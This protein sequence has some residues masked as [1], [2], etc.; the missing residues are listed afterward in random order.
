MRNHELHAHAKQVQRSA[1][2]SSV[3]AA[4]YRAAERL[5]DER[6]GEIHDYTAKQGVEHTRI[7]TPDNAPA[8]A[9]DRSRLWNAAEVKENRDNSTTA[10]ELEVG[11]PSEFNAMQR[12]EAGDRIAQELVRRYGCAVDIAYHQPSRSGDQRNHHAHV[13]FT[14][15]A[16]DATRPD[17]WART[18]YRDLAHDLKDK[19]TGEKYRDQ[20]G[21]PTTRGKLE[22]ADLR[23]FT[24][25][26]M[27]RIAQRDRLQVHT[28]HLSFERRGIDREPTQKMGSHA[29]RMERQGEKSRRGDIN[30]EIIA[31]NDNQARLQ[32][33]FKNTQARRQQQIP[34]NPDSNADRAKRRLDAM[35]REQELS[36][37]KSALERQAAALRQQM[38]QQNRLQRFWSNLTGKTAQRSAEI[39]RLRQSQALL[40]RQREAARQDIAV[41]DRERERLQRQQDM[42]REAFK[43]ARRAQEPSQ[44]HQRY[45][46]DATPQQ[47][48]EFSSAADREKTRDQYIEEHFRR[49]ARGRENS[50][51]HDR[52]GPSME[53]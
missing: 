45:A 51:S 38:E 1:G 11:F 15:R 18:K 48:Q 14:T 46:N 30:R 29:T 24:A 36:R 49:V 53:R 50:R 52:G 13:M 39:E 2:R 28:E 23:S 25:S 43:A 42:A 32:V 22:I 3:A 17:G 34:G 4:A 19:T 37:R 9:L 10:H 16:F 35:I 27:N 12:R 41:Q 21:K 26:E 33:A 47:R 20:D 7:Y 6:T 40:D 5:E 8:W 44:G 31:A